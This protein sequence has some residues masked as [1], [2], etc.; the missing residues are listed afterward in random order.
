MDQVTNLAI[1]SL[2]IVL[3]LAFGMSVARWQER[4]YGRKD[5]SSEE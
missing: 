3:L 5:D 1:V 4:K 2:Y